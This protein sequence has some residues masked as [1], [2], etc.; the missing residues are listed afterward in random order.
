LGQVVKIGIRS[1]E[2][3]NERATEFKRATERKSD[4]LKERHNER[5][6]KSKE[7]QNERAT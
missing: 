6:T 5:V 2:R 1:K 7:R 4:K 3:H